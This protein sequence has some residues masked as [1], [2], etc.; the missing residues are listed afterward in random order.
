MDN[1]LPGKHPVIAKQLPP[2]WGINSPPEDREKHSRALASIAFT[3]SGRI[4]KYVDRNGTWMDYCPTAEDGALTAER[5]RVLAQ[6]RAVSENS[7]DSAMRTGAAGCVALVVGFLV[8]L[9]SRR[10]KATPTNG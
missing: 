8:G 3:E 5:A 6:A 7:R 1:L 9:D 10:K 4:L 2:E